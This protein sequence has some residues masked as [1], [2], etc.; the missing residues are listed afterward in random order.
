MIST[1]Y[2]REQC[3]QFNC[4][5]D[6][7][8][9]PGW[10]SSVLPELNWRQHQYSSSS[11]TYCGRLKKQPFSPLFCVVH[12]LRSLVQRS[13][14]LL[15]IMSVQ[16]YTAC[17]NNTCPITHKTFGEIETPVVFRWNPTQ[18]YECAALAQWLRVSSRDPMTNL[19]I[20][21]DCLM[22]D[23]APLCGYSTVETVHT[24]LGD[25]IGKKQCLKN[26]PGT[27]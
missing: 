6:F 8:F 25:L 2:L 12:I 23:I 14:A 3:H 4:N 20:D 19:H 7:K 16:P 18:P 5:F 17:L 24:I 26:G 15:Y 10:Q 27:S 21:R 11:S 22:D 13:R 1:Y 9:R